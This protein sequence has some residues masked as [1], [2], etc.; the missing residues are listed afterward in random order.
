MEPDKLLHFAFSGLGVLT[1]ERGLRWM[2]VREDDAAFISITLALLAGGLKEWADSMGAGSPELGD[3]VAD[4]A[5]V[6]F[7]RFVLAF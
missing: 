1:L 2:G 5:G 7:A 3:F 4:V 6:A